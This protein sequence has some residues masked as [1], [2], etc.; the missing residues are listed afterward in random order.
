MSV[1]VLASL[2]PVEDAMLGA[3]LLVGFS[4]S[5]IT[6]LVLFLLAR[7]RI[8]KERA[9]FQKREMVALEENEARV[10]A[11]IDNTHAG[12]VML[13]ESGSIESINPTAEHL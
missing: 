10:R 7:R 6:L 12:L 5:A 11:I 8:F 9:L 4:T 2:E 3:T 13:D 1:S